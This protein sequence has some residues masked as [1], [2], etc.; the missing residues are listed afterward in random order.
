MLTEAVV[1]QIGRTALNYIAHIVSPISS[2]WEKVTVHAIHAQIRR[3]NDFRC[4]DVSFRLSMSISCMSCE[5]PCTFISVSVD[6]YVLY[7]VP[8]VNCSSFSYYHVRRRILTQQ[9]HAENICLG[10]STICTISCSASMNG[11]EI[12]PGRSLKGITESGRSAC[13]LYEQASS[14]FFTSCAIYSTRRE[15]QYIF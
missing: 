8:K 4:Y 6:V 9:I 5:H 15:N 14:I 10:M 2:M 13:L 12:A 1:F 11:K 3:A 7:Q